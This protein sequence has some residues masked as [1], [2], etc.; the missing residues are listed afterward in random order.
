M[1]KEKQ[2]ITRQIVDQGQRASRGA[3][4]KRDLQE[5]LPARYRCRGQEAK[6]VGKSGKEQG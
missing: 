5:E 4:D 1:K 6:G 2:G 3:P